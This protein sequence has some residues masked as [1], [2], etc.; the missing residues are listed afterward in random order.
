[1]TRV[2]QRLEGDRPREARTRALVIGAGR[3]PHAK[4][5][6]P[7]IP[8][9]NDLSS[10]GPSVRAF[11]AKLV[12]EWR[13]DLAAPLGTVDLLISDG[14]SPGGATWTALGVPGEAADGTRLDEPTLGNV[15]AA[16][17]AWLQAADAKD[18]LHFLC[19]GHGF[20]KDERCFVLSD[21]GANVNNPWTSVI[22]LDSFAL[23]LRQQPPRTQWLFCDA[24]SDMPETV[25]TSLGMVGDPLIR[26]TAKGLAKAQQKFGPVSQFGLASSTIGTQ[27][28]GIPNKPSRFC[29]ML[30]DALD[31]AGAIFHQYGI[32]W[33]DQ[34]GIVDAIMSYAVRKPDLQDPAFY[35]FVTPISSDAPGH[36]RFR[37][38]ADEPRSRLI[39]VSI[40]PIA[41]KN[42]AIVIKR[43][44]TDRPS[45]TL[46]PPQ[47][48]AE[49]H[50]DL[51]PAR[52]HYTVTAT[53]DG[54]TKQVEIFADL[55]LAERAEF[56][57]P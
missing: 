33:V 6:N 52:Q 57:L 2:Y 38:V 26:L 34:R 8:R 22:A 39:A 15:N 44:G 55:P 48:S 32:W 18:H 50:V 12:R 7:N 46:L 40:P 53:F 20:W 29:E 21:F 16:L 13:S 9:L 4:G 14:A 49:L 25:L 41:L 17:T 11:V 51:L 1:M 28:F 37:R 27:A 47:P 42:A 31:G 30:I 10:V 54:I 45:F 56:I 24:C 36:M 5:T 19:C 35:E 23:G 43:E 3:Y